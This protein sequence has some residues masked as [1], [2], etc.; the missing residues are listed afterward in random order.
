MR[1][2]LTLFVGWLIAVV[3]SGL[4][5]SGAAAIAGGQVTDRPLQPLSA[6]EVAALPVAPVFAQLAIASGGPQEPLDERDG[7][8]SATGNESF[9]EERAVAADTRGFV[10]RP[11]REPVATPLNPPLIAVPLDPID[12]AGDTAEASDGSIF[13]LAGGAFA[14]GGTEQSVVLLW[15]TPRSGFATAVEYVSPTELIV[16]FTGAEVNSSVRVLWSE[17][18]LV[19]TSVEGEAR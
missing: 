5:A 11:D 7:D 16:S 4:V 15:A 17:G 2:R 12:I 18:G 9:D 10:V 14:V 1:R 19:G 13:H 6:A 3:G 8:T